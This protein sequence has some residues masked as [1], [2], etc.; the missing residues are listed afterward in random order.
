M[1]SKSLHELQKE[2]KGWLSVITTEINKRSTLL[3]STKSISMHDECYNSRYF[4]PDDFYYCKL[5]D[6][7]VQLVHGSQTYFDKTGTSIQ[8]G[9]TL[10]WYHVECTNWYPK[11][12]V[13]CR[14]I[15]S[16]TACYLA[17]EN[18][19][20][21]VSWYQK[22]VLEMFAQSGMIDLPDFVFTVIEDKELF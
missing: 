2:M 18:I 9:S 19:D 21:A 11:K 22:F 10:K 16:P 8:S 14:F 20:V 12:L 4:Q 15:H 7:A 17:T 1:T 6:K 3:E 5:F 13:D